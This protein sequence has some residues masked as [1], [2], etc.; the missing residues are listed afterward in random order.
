MLW[1][2]WLSEEEG[3]SGGL[4]LEEE[5]FSCPAS[6]FLLRAPCQQTE[7]CSRTVLLMDSSSVFLA[8]WG[9]KYVLSAWPPDWRNN[10]KQASEGFSM[11]GGDDVWLM[12]VR[13]RP[14]ASL[15]EGKVAS[16][17]RWSLKPP[18]LCWV[19][20]AVSSTA[21]WLW[22]GLLEP[23]RSLNG[24]A[25]LGWEPGCPRGTDRDLAVIP[26]HPTTADGRAGLAGRA[27][28]RRSPPWSVRTLGNSNAFLTGL[29]GG[30]G[31][32][33]PLQER[34]SD[35]RV[36]RLFYWLFKSVVV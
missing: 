36:E 27:G 25:G 13:V 8:A 28:N 9:N 18:S 19:L 12:W 22:A 26:D 11:G 35:L 6:E 29:Q 30:L 16:F 3:N 33:Q 17:S 10:C 32:R 2:P 15:A 21:L 23:S 24:Q 4:D 14:S 5:P 34:N 1:I 20:T 7:R 31:C